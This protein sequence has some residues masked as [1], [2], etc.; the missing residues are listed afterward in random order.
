M[1]KSIT[2][3][4]H[5]F[6]ISLFFFIS[7]SLFAQDFDDK[8][9]ESLPEDISSDLLNRTL[10]KK[11]QQEVQYRKSSTSIDKPLE[12]EIYLRNI[13]KAEH[14]EKAELQEKEIK[15]FGSE[16]FSLM[17]ST[18]MP[19]NEPNFDGNYVLDYGDQIEVQLAGQKSQTYVLN[20]KRDGSIS[21][22]EIGKVYVS[23]SSLNE[24]SS[25]I[26]QKINDA[27][28]GTNAYISLVNIR[29][30]QVILAGNVSNP[31]SYT[32]NGNSNIFHALHVA[33]GPSD[34]GSFR[35]INLVRGNST[36]ETIDL[37]DT[38]IGGINAFKTRLR[39]GDIIFI[40]PV[41]KIVTI[42]GGINRAA[43][44]ELLSNEPLS[45]VLKFA[46]GLSTY[47]DSSSISIERLLDGKPKTIPIINIVQLDNIIA[48]DGD[49]IYIKKFS[50]RK[51]KIRGS[52]LRPGSYM[53]LEGDSIQDLIK[54]A[55]GFSP[56]AYPLGGIYEN[57][58]TKSLNKVAIDTLYKDFLDKLVLFG[59]NPQAKTDIGSI[60]SLASMVKDTEP[61]GRVIVDFENPNISN[62]IYL[63]EGDSILIPEITNQVYVYGSVSS[64]GAVMH[65]KNADISYYINNKGG[66]LEIADTRGIYV[67]FPNGESKRFKM[68]KNLFT[69]QSEEFQIPPGSVIYV[70]KEID[71]TIAKSIVAQAY[72]T[73]LGNISVSLASISVLKD[74]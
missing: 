32:L 1:D 65:K 50:F 31:G 4:I 21:L 44:Y 22:P 41:G 29:D 55:G 58:F 2:K 12:D 64:E 38:F 61:S 66:L 15:R 67:L 74:R 54:K 62:T 7:F 3:L 24:A 39:S 6:F 33:G 25:L 63:Q 35:S 46:N 71:D 40:N 26:K 48:K 37:Y 19:T 68:N 8:F 9:L 17:Q 18:F 27:Y 45:L 43:E 20:I 47:A 36:I 49:H 60:V 16:I 13:D 72:A 14:E 11:S 10:E 69:K 34:M 73:I 51:V 42:D 53:M 5:S 52:V 59:S 57:E 28:I 30:I 70:P 56:N 23:G